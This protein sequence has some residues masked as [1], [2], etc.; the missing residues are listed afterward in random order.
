MVRLCEEACFFYSLAFQSRL[1]AKMRISL[2]DQTETSQKGAVF[3]IS[4]KSS[5]SPELQFHSLV[6]LW[7]EAE[8]RW[9]GIKLSGDLV[10][11]GVSDMC[12][13]YAF[14]QLGKLEWYLDRQAAA[15]ERR[16]QSEGTRVKNFPEL[17]WVFMGLAFLEFEPAEVLAGRDYARLAQDATARSRTDAVSSFEELARSALERV[18]E[19]ADSIDKS[20]WPPSG[21]DPTHKL[22]KPFASLSLELRGSSQ[23][24]DT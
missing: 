14:D 18:R 22:L 20:K 24:E 6:L 12:R 13:L 9:R 3:D 7:L 23:S 4:L 10:L 8:L 16:R 15:L 17:S 11:P 1:S 21:A 2:G 19:F 5:L